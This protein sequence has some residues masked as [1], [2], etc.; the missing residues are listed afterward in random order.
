MKYTTSAEPTHTANVTTDHIVFPPQANTPSF[1]C[2]KFEIENIKNTDPKSE[3][4]AEP[5]KPVFNNLLSTS[6]LCA[7]DRSEL[8]S[9]LMYSLRVWAISEEKRNQL[10]E[11]TS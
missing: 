1:T 6:A 5:S 9:K 4:N 10:K 3:P 7:S 11:M 8:L 2:M